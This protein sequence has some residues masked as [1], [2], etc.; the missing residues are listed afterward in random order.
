MFGKLG[1]SGCSVELL[2][3]IYESIGSRLAHELRMEN[4][5]RKI[6]QDI[7]VD[8]VVRIVNVQSDLNQYFGIVLANK[9]WH[10]GI[11]GIVESIIK[12]QYNRSVVVIS[13]NENK[14]GIRSSR[15]LSDFDMYKALDHISDCLEGFGGHPIAAGL[16][17][18]EANV[19][20]FPK[21]F[22]N[23]VKVQIK[24]NDLSPTLILDR[25]L[26]LSDID[27]RVISFLDKLG[28]HGPM[29]M[30]QKFSIKNV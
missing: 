8:E 9:D 29:N 3:T 13:I 28:P 23:Y 7:I 16:S 14:R 25:E 12:E 1:N 17:I 22:L 20:G 15:S 5:K 10:Q 27:G 19:G 24:E 2:M 26:N 30:R 6:I 11:I 18:I 21:A 4:E